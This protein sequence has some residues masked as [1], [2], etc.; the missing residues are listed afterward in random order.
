M[1]SAIDGAQPIPEKSGN[2]ALIKKPKRKSNEPMT[3]PAL[4]AKLKADYMTGQYNSVQLSDKHQ[5]NHR[6]VHAYVMTRGWRKEL[7]ESG[8]TPPT[9]PRL[10]PKWHSDELWFKIETDYMNGEAIGELSVKYNVH[11]VTIQRRVR[12]RGWKEARR[13][14][15]TAMRQGYISDVAGNVLRFD[16][17]VQKFLESSI[18]Q[19]QRLLNEVERNKKPNGD[20]DLKRFGE[21]IEIFSKLYTAIKKVPGIDLVPGLLKKRTNGFEAH[22]VDGLDTAVSAARQK[23]TP[24]RVDKA[25]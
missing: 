10:A 24:L 4:L 9:E 12:R 8:I 1:E 20:F 17:V 14:L 16:A 6:S 2:P 13:R 15:K 7:E 11:P 22:F 19:M 18:E 21:I 23:A 5:A 25:S 3:S